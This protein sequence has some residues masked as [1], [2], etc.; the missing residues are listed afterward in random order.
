MALTRAS[1]EPFG[2]DLFVVQ[3]TPA[4]NPVLLGSLEVTTSAG[5][6]SSLNAA[7]VDGDGDDDLI[8]TMYDTAG[9]D[10]HVIENQGG[11]FAVGPLI[12]DIGGNAYASRSWA[13]DWDGDG[14]DDL[15]YFDYSSQFDTGYVYLAEAEGLALEAL[16]LGQVAVSY[17]HLTLPTIYSV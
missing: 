14:D 8:F 11:T 9:D 12:D 1:F 3:W 15:A 5:S 16:G 13:V 10:A 17:T 6:A 7:D 2:D 4:G